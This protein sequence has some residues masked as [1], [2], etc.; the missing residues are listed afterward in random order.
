MFDPGCVLRGNDCRP[1]KTFRAN[2]SELA[3]SK[4]DSRAH[5]TNQSWRKF[6]RPGRAPHIII[7]FR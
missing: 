6:L 7:E 3:L 5:R 2:L 4:S 1:G